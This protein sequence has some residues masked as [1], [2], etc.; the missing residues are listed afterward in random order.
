MSENQNAKDNMHKVKPVETCTEMEQEIEKI[1]KENG[2]MVN[3]NAIDAISVAKMQRFGLD[4][5][6][7]CPCDGKNKERF[8]GS[9]LC[10]QEIEEKGVCFCGLFKKG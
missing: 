3:E 9:P 10:A 1:A 5:W 8:C 4:A 7:P 6:H 2:W